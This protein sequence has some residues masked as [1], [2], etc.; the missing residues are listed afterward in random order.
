MSPAVTSIPPTTGEDV[1]PTCRRCIV[2]LAD[3]AL[4]CGGCQGYVHYKCSGLPEYQLIRLAVSQSS[5][6]CYDCVKAKDLKG[7]NEKFSLEAE[8]IKVQIAKENS[9]AE[10]NRSTNTDTDST[11][12][13]GE[14]N[15]E[16][17]INPTNANP[18]PVCKYYLQKSCKYGRKGDGC[19]YSHPKLCFSYIKRGDRRG[20]CKK[21]ES[22]N[23][24][25][26]KLCQ[27]ALDTRVC[28]NNRC[29]FYHVTGTNST[30]MSDARI[31]PNDSPTAPRR[32][33]Q[34][35]A[36]LQRQ[37]PYRDSPQGPEVSSAQSVNTS[38]PENRHGHSNHENSRGGDSPPHSDPDAFLEM[39][40]Q[41][42]TMQDQMI[43]I[44]TL[45]KPTT[46]NQPPTPPSVGWG[47]R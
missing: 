30:N 34:R 25:H 45:L 47:P 21:G 26:P 43:L 41:M 2:D 11:D 13:N 8:K 28:T 36:L 39:K 20:G 40:Q 18:F 19:N 1:R 12:Q 46:S 9:L 22:C 16:N 32:I 37:A 24:V 7:D 44:M 33:L 29:R 38:A 17:Q 14:S 15:A 6:N 31:G 3:S 10:L 35:P 23:Y 27:R 5:Y 4:K 42:R